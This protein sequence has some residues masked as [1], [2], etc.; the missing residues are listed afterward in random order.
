VIS[1][2]DPDGTSLLEK[3]IG[4]LFDPAPDS[5]VTGAISN[6]RFYGEL[7]AADIDLDGKTEVVG[8]F[9]LD[10]LYV[11]KEDGQRKWE[12]GLPCIAT[13]SLADLDGDDSLEVVVN[14]RDSSAVYVFTNSGHA[15]RCNDEMFASQLLDDGGDWN[16]AGVAVAD[17]GGGNGDTLEIIQSAPTGWVYA[18]KASKGG[19]PGNPDSLWRAAVASGGK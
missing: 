19:C 14:R 17:L 13:P 16:Y 5:V 2:W 12:F 11:V 7:A 10:S 9:G 6:L 3:T 8:S 4:V 15:Y 1:A 18:W